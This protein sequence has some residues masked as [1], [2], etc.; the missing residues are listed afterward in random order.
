MKGLIVLKLEYELIILLTKQDLNEGE[1]N[2]LKELLGSH[3]EWDRIIGLLY[4]H[5]VLGI[6]WLN[7]KDTILKMKKIDVLCLDYLNS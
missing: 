4:I 6:A 2:R 3:L 7:L 1:I 5:R